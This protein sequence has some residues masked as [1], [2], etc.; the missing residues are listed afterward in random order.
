MKRAKRL[1]FSS[2]A[3]LALAAGAAAADLPNWK[4]ET[5]AEYVKV[6]KG[7]DVAGFAIPGAD[8]CLKVGGYVDAQVAMGAAT[9]AYWASTNA[10]RATSRSVGGI[11]FDARGQIDFDAGTNTAYGPLLAHIELRADA[12]DKSFDW[13]SGGAA[14]EAGYAQWAGFTVGRRR[15]FYWS[16]P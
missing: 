7:G 3:A 2:A 11:G 4:G 1:L 10:L 9:N 16:A 15:S 8:A 13:A 6:C 5:A 12:G 14:L